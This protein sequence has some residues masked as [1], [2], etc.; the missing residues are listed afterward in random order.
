[1]FR[2]RPAR[3]VE[4]NR[5]LASEGKPQR[6]NPKEKLSFAIYFAKYMG[7]AIAEALRSEYPTVRSGENPSLSVRGPKRVDLNYSTPEMGLGFALSF[8]SVHFG[9]KQGGDADFIHNLKRNDEELRG[10]AAAHHIRQPFAVLGALVFLPFES[11]TDMSP[12]SFASWVEY[13]WPSRAASNRGST[14][15]IRA[16]LPR[17]ICA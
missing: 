13:L 3:R 6:A 8:K 12:S 4:Q 5:R 16:C 15:S 11:C 17:L 1:M 2:R 7:G 14:G 9:E 10:E